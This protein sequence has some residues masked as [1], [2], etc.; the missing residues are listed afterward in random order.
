MRTHT[1]LLFA[2]IAALSICLGGSTC[3]KRSNIGNTSSDAAGP[4]GSS[5]PDAAVD[6]ADSGP[7]AGSG[8]GGSPDAADGAG[9]DTFADTGGPGDADASADTVANDTGTADTNDS[10]TDA[11]ICQ[12]DPNEPNDAAGNAEPLPNRGR[13]TRAISAAACSGDVDWYDFSK[14]YSPSAQ[15]PSGALVDVSVVHEV[16]GPDLSVELWRENRSGS[17][18][19]V[20]SASP[21]VIQGLRW[22]YTPSRLETRDAKLYTIRHEPNLSRDGPYYVKVSGAGSPVEYSV[23]GVYR[24]DSRD[25]NPCTDDSKEPNDTTSAATVIQAPTSFGQKD[26]KDLRL[27]SGDTDV[28]RMTVP[29][30]ETYYVGINYIPSTVGKMSIRTASGRSFGASMPMEPLHE[31]WISHGFTAPAGSQPADV[32]ITIEHRTSSPY[33]GNYSLNVDHRSSL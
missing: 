7:E 4:N 33:L 28:Y 11:G 17:L 9:S 14:I 2:T 26:V 27:C 3:Q 29:A 16:P 21:D 6:A 24:E 10:S 19:R 31:G 25:D 13:G 23:Y 12:S 8:G 20:Q 32:I 1:N 15:F 30:G 22:S 18:E 5:S